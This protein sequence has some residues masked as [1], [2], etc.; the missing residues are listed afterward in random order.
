MIELRKQK[1]CRLPV[2]FDRLIKVIARRKGI[3]ENDVIVYLLRSGLELEQR[4]DQV[5]QFLA[6]RTTSVKAVLSL[7]GVGSS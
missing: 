2:R 3:A 4:A 1:L 6:V 7:L 5:K